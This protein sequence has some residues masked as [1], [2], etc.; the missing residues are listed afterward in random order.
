ME[1]GE[2]RGEGDGGGVKCVVGYMESEWVLGRIVW[3]G[4]GGV[5]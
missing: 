4:K 3:R 1:E 5:M 2:F